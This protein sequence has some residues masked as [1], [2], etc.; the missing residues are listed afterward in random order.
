M[1]CAICGKDGADGLDGKGSPAHDWCRDAID[2][3]RVEIISYFTSAQM[4][5]SSDAVDK[6]LAYP[7]LA[8]DS[9]WLYR[10][11]RNTAI[12]FSKQAGRGY[13]N[14]DDV[15]IEIELSFSTI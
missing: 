2:L 8:L 9:Q 15:I 3:A 11:M 7:K 5:I 6:I 10:T 12:N 14:A 13:V 1:I 4:L